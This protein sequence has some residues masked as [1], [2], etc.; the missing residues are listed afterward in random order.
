MGLG[1]LSIES[2]AAT[3]CRQFLDPN[4]AP[5]IFQENNYFCGPACAAS[6]L[7]Q[8]RQEILTQDQLGQILNTNSDVGTTPK[9]MFQGLVQLGLNVITHNH[10][11]IQSLIVGLKNQ[12]HYLLLIQS[13][14]EAHW[15]IVTGQSDKSFI[16]MDPWPETKGYVLMTEAELLRR[17]QTSIGNKYFR[18]FAIEV[19]L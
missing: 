17:W 4:L 3:P 19:Y 16:L 13:D 6:L 9:N 18:Q 10:L 2:Q 14:S 12:K 7:N 8:F 1:S 15:V 5:V 11:E